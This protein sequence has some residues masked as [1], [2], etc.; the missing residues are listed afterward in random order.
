MPES[1]EGAGRH[2]RISVEQRESLLDAVLAGIRRLLRSAEA[3]RRE[4]LSPDAADPDGL[5]AVAGGLYTYAVEEYGKALLIESLPEKGGIIS[6]PYREIFGS[7]GKKFEAA[8]KDLPVECSAIGA[9]VFD[10]HI[11]DPRIFD[12]GLQATF[13]GRMRLLYLDMDRKGGP[14][15]EDTPDARMLAG[16]LSGLDQALARK[17]RG[18]PAKAGGV[19]RRARGA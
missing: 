7:H 6:V 10:P 5:L 1:A 16:A 8:L 12:T 14:I 2:Q 18:R 13:Q 11:F 3:L 9:G 15:V 17:E 19:A 4:A